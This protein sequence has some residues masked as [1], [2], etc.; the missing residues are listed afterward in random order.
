MRAEQ[1]SEL[2]RLEGRT[3]S[4]ALADGSRLDD[5]SLVSAGS[6]T[7]W[8]FANGEDR[9][10]PVGQVIDVWEALSPAA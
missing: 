1:R 4:L 2:L 5:V 9:F 3:V 8:V 10:I 7:V 6:G